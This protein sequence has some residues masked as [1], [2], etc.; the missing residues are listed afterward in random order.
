[1]DNF[2]SFDQSYETAI[3]G[4]AGRF[5]GARSVQEFWQNL[6]D[7][8]ESISFF[9]DEELESATAAGSAANY[10]KAGAVL[11]D[12]EQFDASFFGFT[13]REAEIMDPQHRIFLETAWEAL[14]NTGYDPQTYRRRIGV[15]A[16]VGMKTYLLFNLNANYELIESVDPLKMGISNEKDHLP[17]YV[18]YK[19]NL[20]GP[21]VSV[22]TTCSTS[23]VAVHLACQSLLNGECD[24]AL[25]GGVAITVPQKTGYFYQEGGIASPD[26]HCR[27]FDANAQGTI[28]GNGVGIVVLK[29]LA[30]AITDGD[31]IYAVIKGSAINNDGS[32]K[33]G[34]T[35]P[36]VDGQAEV[37]MEAQAVAGVEPE[38]LT[39][40]EAHGTG[41]PLGDPIEIAALSQAFRA[42]TEKK[43][44]CAIGSVKTNI[45]HLDAAA[46]VAGLIKTALALKY[47][48]LPPSLYVEQ[49]NPKIDFANSPFYVNTKLSEWKTG[50]TPRRAGV[51]S[52]GIGGTNAHVVLEEAPLG[53][54]SGKSKPW[55]LL[56]LSAK[57]DTALQN[58][59]TRLVE[60]LKQYPDLNLAD[61][62]YTLQIGR[63]DFAHRRML[64]CHDL[65][66]ALN[67]LEAMDSKRVFTAIQ[68]DKDRP[69]V[70]MF[71]GQGAQY[72]NMA[73][74]LYQIEQTFR[75]QVDLCSELL[76]PHLRFDL[77]NAIYPDKEQIDEASHQLAQTAI[78]Q[79][80][81]FVIEYAL[82]Q[83][84]MKWGVH[85][86]AMI[87]H[88][89]GEYVAAC[90]AGVFSLEDALALVA[91]RGQMMQKLPGGTMLAVPLSEK[92]LYPL[93]NKHLSLA[94][95]N[96]P[97]RCVVSGPVDNVVE[98]EH[99]LSQQDVSYQR[100]HTSHAFHSD[101][102]DPI[103]GSFAEH[104]KEVSLKPP[105]VPFVSNL[106]GTWI[107]AA[108]ATDPG[109]WARHLRQT[110]RFAE[111]IHT[112]LR[113]PDR[114]L[115]EVGPG[116]TLSTLARQH[117]SRMA[118]Q[119]VFSSSGHVRD[120][121]SD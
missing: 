11:E 77:R 94:A 9:S 53:E 14:E 114:L 85:P 36:S 33:V 37:I 112:L 29:R 16:G 56:I 58:V 82:A 10:V 52:F 31:T 98:L 42:G 119:A 66:D 73:L 113:E 100:L 50:E 106:T 111:G 22:N 96:G 39:Y 4:M 76:Q 65:E 38:T 81:L 92:Q 103:L 25:A 95:I 5:P 63:R 118:Q 80:A 41:T 43:G 8:I 46:G 61:V 121:S 86:Q 108:E 18:S 49:P 17:T 55:H 59:T 83:L 102:M 19:L 60:H 27:A 72:V 24:M 68:E 28:R 84:W 30:D 23:L 93:L 79:P 120:E 74:E 15:Y 87:G 99:Q 64:V 7:G 101:M 89:I 115:L 75:E 110:V 2:N 54:P 105:K 117:P 13:P 78:T 57:T 109:Y 48:L 116:Q 67:A 62:A 71:P 47:Q 20:R 51:S 1:M 35:A 91:A 32:L 90:L 6:Q 70:F 107:T 21:S 12:I 26:G 45:G 104:V 3:I 97:S 69:V 44:F 88:S 34:Y 40:I